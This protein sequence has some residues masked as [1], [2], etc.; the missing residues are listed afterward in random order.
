MDLAH[1]EI[2][3][4]QVYQQ[5]LAEAL[6]SAGRPVGPDDFN[7]RWGDRLRLSPGGYASSKESALGHDLRTP[8]LLLMAM[9]GL[10][11]VVAAG[12]VANLFLARGEARSREIAIRFALGASRWRVLRQ[13]LVESLL[14][15]L[16]AGGVGLL[17]ARWTTWLAPVVLNV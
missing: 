4:N 15:A 5:I 7:R 14:L 12:N 10:V 2:A 16:T 6:A 9:V 11:L 17:L 13:L 1:A 8:L 3:G